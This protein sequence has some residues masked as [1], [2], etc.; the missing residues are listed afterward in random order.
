MTAD[1]FAA[2]DLVS[3]VPHAGFK[4]AA[5]GHALADALEALLTT[6]GAPSLPSEHAALSALSEVA[7]VLRGAGA[8][9]EEIKLATTAFQ[10]VLSM[11]R[12][13]RSIL[14]SRQCECADAAEKLLSEAGALRAKAAEAMGE[15][16]GGKVI[17]A[18]KRFRHTPPHRDL[19]DIAAKY[20]STPGGEQ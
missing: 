1:G 17:W 2:G 14:E 19:I 18:G 16:V 11:L 8:S 13:T 4:E 15:R 12:Q 5:A 3:I 9:E 20:D 6:L 10:P 7:D